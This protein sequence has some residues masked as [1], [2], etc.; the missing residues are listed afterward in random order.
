M[1]DS[2]K[3]KTLENYFTFEVEEEK[4]PEQKE[5]IVI[6]TDGSCLLN[7]KNKP[8]GWGVVIEV[9]GE[10]VKQFSRSVENTTNQRMELTAAIEAVKVLKD[11]TIATI[12]SDSSYVICGI[13][14]WIHNWKRTGKSYLNKDLWDTLYTLV[15]KGKNIKI[16]WEYVKGHSGHYGNDLADKLAGIASSSICQ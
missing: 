14:E 13:T 3:K 9:D 4:E 5:K 8:G 12:M 1:I 10:I 16:K 2:E 6:Y 15:Y 11:N 7:R